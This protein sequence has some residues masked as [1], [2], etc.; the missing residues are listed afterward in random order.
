M[1]KMIAY[2]VLGLIGVAVA[3]SVFVR[4]APSDPARWHVDP[5]A[6]ADPGMGG[7]RYVPTP[8]G[9]PVPVYDLPPEDLI[10]ALDRF[11]MAQP[12]VTR[13]AGSAAEGRI[14]YV[15][16]S[17][18]WGF[19]DHVTVEALALGPDRATLA[20]LSRLRY[21]GSD[22]GVNRARIDDWLGRF[23]PGA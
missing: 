14:T 7:V 5:V 17:A 20:I 16:R 19:P 3:L 21:G 15:V 22:M 13:L 1:L 6:A 10:A 8:E 11:A 18:L 4:L 12:R 9:G 2:I 23:D